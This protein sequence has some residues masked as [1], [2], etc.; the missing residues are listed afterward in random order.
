ME[1]CPIYMMYG[2][3]Y[4][5]FWYEDPWLAYFYREMYIARRKDE[6]YRDWIQGAYFY[7]ALTTALS[8]AFRKTG[9]KVQNYIEEPFQLFKKTKAEKEV[10]VEHEKK[11]A[12]DF[13]RLMM[14]Q[15]HSR[16]KASKE[17]L[18]NGETRDP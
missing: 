17:P 13:M 14:A 9:A 12:E 10:Q 7:N 4:D 6:N 18:E 1:A 8:N 3:T 2:M 15:Q 11:A 16:N 5:Q